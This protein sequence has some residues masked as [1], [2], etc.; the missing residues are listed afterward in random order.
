MKKPC[1]YC[2]KEFNIKYLK[3]HQ[4][5]CKKRQKSFTNEIQFDLNSARVKITDPQL[6][7]ALGT[8]LDEFEKEAAKAMTEKIQE[9]PQSF[10]E[11]L[12]RKD[13]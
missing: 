6:K 4:K 8:H 2:R 9:E 12:K 1:K 10:I 5:Y 3:I 7:A 11:E 13:T